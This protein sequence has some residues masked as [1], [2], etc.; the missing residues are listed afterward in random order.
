MDTPDTHAADDLLPRG[1]YAAASKPSGL[2]RK[3]GVTL[4][5][6]A[7][8]AYGAPFRVLMAMIHHF[9]SVLPSLYALPIYINT[10][11]H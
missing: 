7:F 3:S 11:V 5:L 6:G 2:E 1:Q 9:R 8:S 10:T 4:F